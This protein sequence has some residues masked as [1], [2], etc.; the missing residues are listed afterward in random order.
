MKANYTKPLLA[1]EMFSFVQTA[2]RDCND[3]IP[4]N[5]LNFNDPGTCVWDLGRGVTVFSDTKKCT[6]D[7][8]NM[9]VG[10][11]NNP[12]EGNYVFRS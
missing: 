4:K 7:G 2:A 10:C 11:Y 9:D 5:Q 1:V 6:I 12:T 3:A 8:T